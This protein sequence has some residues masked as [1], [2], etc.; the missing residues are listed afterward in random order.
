MLEDKA[1]LKVTRDSGANVKTLRRLEALGLITLTDILIE[2][3]REN[4]KVKNKAL[5]VGVWGE[6][7]WGEAIWAS[8]NSSYDRIKEI[9]GVENVKDSIHLEAHIR[10]GNDIFVTEDNDFLTIREELKQEFGCVVMH[11]NELKAKLTGE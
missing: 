2:N 7:R 11:P 3:G 5:P 10:M 6:T 8:E 9:I 1:P 4:R